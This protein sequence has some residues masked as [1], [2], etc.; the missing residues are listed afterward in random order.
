MVHHLAVKLVHDAYRGVC[1]DT[2]T[3]IIGI[4]GVLRW[5]DAAEFILAGA[6]AVQMGTASFVDPRLPEKAVKGLRSWTRRQGA[7]SILD[8]IGA[9]DLA[10]PGR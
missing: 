2:Q 3:P 5:A 4:G 10:R 8:L 7:S 1:K 9:V 6:T